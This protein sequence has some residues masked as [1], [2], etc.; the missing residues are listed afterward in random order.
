MKKV[1]GKHRDKETAHPLYLQDVYN[2][3]RTEKARQK[4][5][6]RYVRWFRPKHRRHDFCVTLTG[7]K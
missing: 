5:W 6:C 7:N 4:Q 3:K 2:R 1:N